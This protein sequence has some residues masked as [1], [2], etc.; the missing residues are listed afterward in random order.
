MP[1]EQSGDYFSRLQNEIDAVEEGRDR[2]GVALSRRE[3]LQR[4]LRGEVPFVA[5]VARPASSADRRVPASDTLDAHPGNAGAARRTAAAL[6]RQTSGRDRDARDARAAQ[7]APRRRNRRAA[8]RRS[9]ARWPPPARLPIRS[10][11]ASS[12]R[13]TRPT[14]RSP[15]CAANSPS[16]SRKVAELRSAR[17]HRAAGRSRIRAAQP[18][19]RSHARGI[20]RAGRPPAEGAPVGTRR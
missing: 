18:R 13:S 5:A 7:A 20:P 11:R 17:R 12:W 16:I 19:L 4:Q 2:P 6:H 15:R 8:P 1:G 10:S 14:S 9:V 3:E